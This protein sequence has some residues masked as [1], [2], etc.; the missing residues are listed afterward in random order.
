MWD[1]PCHL[2]HL[3]AGKGAKELAVNIEDFVIDIY[4]HFWRSA[5]HKEQLREFMEFN[6]NEVRKVIKYVSTRWLSLGKCLER[7]LKQ[8]DSLESY[9]LSYFDLQDDTEADGQTNRETRLVKAFKSPITRLYAMFVQ[10]VIPVF[11][12]FNTFLQS[13]EPLIHILLQSTIRLHRSLLTRFI[14]P[15]VI[16]SSEELTH[17]D[18]DNPDFLR[19]DDEIFIGAMSKQYAQDSDIIGTSQYKKFLKECKKFYD[20]HQVLANI[21]ASVTQRSDKIIHLFETSRK[22]SSIN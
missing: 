17:I 16:S 2:A 21:N 15:Q 20:M 12:S 7:T 1:V 19:S 9:F 5:K 14:R 6:N 22:A 13:E 18:L 3:C 10:S 4:Y 8:W 11:D